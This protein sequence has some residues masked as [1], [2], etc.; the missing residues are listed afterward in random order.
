MKKQFSSALTALALVPFC[1]GAMSADADDS[2]RVFVTIADENGALALAQAEVE[3]TDTDGDGA[4]TICDALYA[5]HEANYPG[6]A[7]AGFASSEGQYGLQL[8]QLWGAENGTGYGYYVNHTSAMSLG[9]PISDG[10]YVAAF[11]YTDTTAWS[12]SYCWFNCNTA[13]AKESETITL[14]LSAAGYD[15]NWNPI[16][17]PVAGAVITING[18]KTEYVTDENGNA[19]ISFESADTYLISAVS[20][21]QILVPPV[22]KIAVSAQ[23]TTAATTTEQETTTTQTTTA[24]A[25]TAPT[26][27]DS[28][29]GACFITAAVLS[30]VA[31]I[32]ARKKNE[33][34]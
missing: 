20:D 4:L 23:E 8:D 24:S 30:G 16:S 11:V 28:G 12:D 29:I 3:V 27:G 14:T 2:A 22:C 25:Q 10:D 5:A 34:R 32:S 26:T 15:E 19:A 1:V 6:G 21:T 17:L 13:E 18:E 33:T 31:L 7:A 9:D